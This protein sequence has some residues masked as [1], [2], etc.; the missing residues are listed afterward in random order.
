MQG[1]PASCR[2][3]DL[4]K[5]TTGIQTAE[6]RALVRENERLK[7]MIGEKESELAV[8][9]DLP[10]NRPRLPEKLEVAQS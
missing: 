1:E 8:V 9:R 6:M 5:P 7:R 10:K 4:A 2:S 3:V